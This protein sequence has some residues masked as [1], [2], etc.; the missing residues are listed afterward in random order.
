ML[1]LRREIEELKSVRGP[2]DVEDL[3]QGEDLV[4]LYVDVDVDETWYGVGYRHEVVTN[5]NN[6]IKEIGPV[7]MQES[8]ESQFKNRLKEFISNSEFEGSPVEKDSI[9]VTLPSSVFETVKVQFFALGLIKKGSMKRSSADKN[10]YWVLTEHG[11][12]QL[13]KSRALR[14]Q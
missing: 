6:L 11:E 14:R 8:T 5:W 2:R 13:M 4:T 9:Y 3:Q 12:D 1:R 7:L 10:N